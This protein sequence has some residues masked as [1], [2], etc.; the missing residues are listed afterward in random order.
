MA[1]P[2]PIRW[3]RPTLPVLLG[4]AVLVLGASR[5]RAAGCH[6]DERPTLGLT[7]AIDLT[8]N[9]G[10][11]TGFDAGPSGQIA[12]HP[13]EGESP[14]TP[15]RTALAPAPAVLVSPRN[16]PQRGASRWSPESTRIRLPDS[17]PATPE[18]PPR[19]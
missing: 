17:S 10:Q 18:R 12:P 16:L 6:V 15:T 9:P 13:C 4:L 19:D 3:V 11:E 14:T 5:A 8:E 2:A 7:G 1:R